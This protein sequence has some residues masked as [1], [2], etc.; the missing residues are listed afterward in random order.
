M[1]IEELSQILNIILKNYVLPN[2][3]GPLFLH[4]AD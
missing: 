2:S 3:L 1:D 4:S